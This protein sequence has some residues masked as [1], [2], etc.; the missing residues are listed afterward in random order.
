MGK[1]LLKQKETAFVEQFLSGAKK[2]SILQVCYIVN[3][4][5]KEGTD[6]IDFKGFRLISPNGV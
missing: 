2:H 5:G 3:M 1:F 4:N 6:D